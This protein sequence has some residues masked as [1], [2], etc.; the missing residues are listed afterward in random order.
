MVSALARLI[1]S[2]RLGSA[3]TLRSC[4]GGEQVH[5]PTAKRHMALTLGILGMHAPLCLLRVGKTK[6]SRE[7]WTAQPGHMTPFPSA[8]LA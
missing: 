8:N 1:D 4:P 7:P 6:Q 5:F 2:I 3:M